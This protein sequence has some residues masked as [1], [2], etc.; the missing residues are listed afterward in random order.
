MKKYVKKSTLIVVDDVLNKNFEKWD[1]V[2]ILQIVDAKR[3]KI[4]GTTQKTKL[5]QLYEI[6]LLLF[7]KN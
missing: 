4:I 7:K 2:K 1:Q 6:I 5:H 3:S